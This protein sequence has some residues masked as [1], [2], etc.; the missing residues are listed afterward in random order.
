MGSP[1]WTDN[2]PTCFLAMSSTSP[3]DI[4]VVYDA[5]SRPGQRGKAVRA[6]GRRPRPTLL[7]V[8][9]LNLVVAGVL[10][11]ATWWPAD[12]FIYLN[13]VL[14]TPLDV[15][16]DAAAS[17]IVPGLAADPFAGEP[18]EELPE[19]TFVPPAIVGKTAQIVIGVT[20]YSWLA[21]A[22]IAF[23]A[24]GLAGGAGLGRAGGSTW[25]KIGVI[26][27][28]VALL[29]LAW[30]GHDVWSEYGGE[31]PPGKLRAGM[32]GLVLLS[33]LVG[34]AVGRAPR[35]LSRLAAVI[36]IVAAVGS[37]LGL[38]LGKLCGAVD[39]EYSS[40]LFLLIVFVLHS[41]WGW[42]LFPVSVRMRL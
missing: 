7:I 23:C 11:Y 27:S 29:A 24:L 41:L 6:S 16:V 12:K 1:Q 26:L 35:G 32:A 34:L 42:V 18:K 19:D 21:L 4:K 31:Y 36:L 39:P 33:A 15:D 10:C 5:S 22:T 38:Y 37:V 28:L 3:L 40:I 13:F 30:A 2:E 17:A 25:R 20:G 9:L 8:A 14:H